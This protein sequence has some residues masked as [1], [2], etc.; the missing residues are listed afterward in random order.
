MLLMVDCGG[1]WKV[2]VVLK[3]LVKS[4]QR[5]NDL[6]QR[7]AY[8]LLLSVS[9][10]MLNVASTLMSASEMGL[11]FINSATTKAAVQGYQHKAASICFAVMSACL[12]LSL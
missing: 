9:G 10:E 4:W 11:F 3:I 7:K 5:D 6:S 8:R 1:Y 12:P 2:T